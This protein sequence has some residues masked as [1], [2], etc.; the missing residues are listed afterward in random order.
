M[1]MNIEENPKYNFSYYC[2]R[3]VCIHQRSNKNVVQN[4]IIFLTLSCHLFSII[5]HCF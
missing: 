4:V 2:M 1:R 3:F 5:A